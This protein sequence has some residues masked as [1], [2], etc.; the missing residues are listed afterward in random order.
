MI[1]LT[2][3]RERDPRPC[4]GFHEG[5]RTDGSSGTFESST[6]GVVA[7]DVRIALWY[8]DRVK[9]IDEASSTSLV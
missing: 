2:E 8:A 4:T 1:F 7:D 9:P 6:L 3:M 5:S